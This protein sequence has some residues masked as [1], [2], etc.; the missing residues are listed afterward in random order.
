LLNT[1]GA[2]VG[3]KN[4]SGAPLDDLGDASLPHGLVPA[5]LA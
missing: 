4:R 3:C 2:A 5:M 1:T